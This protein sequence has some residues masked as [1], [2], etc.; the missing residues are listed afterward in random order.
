MNCQ[1]TDTQVE[2]H[3]RLHRRVD[4]L[5]DWRKRRG[6]ISEQHGFSAMEL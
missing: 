3:R 5:S 2:H 1:L 6:G 4:A